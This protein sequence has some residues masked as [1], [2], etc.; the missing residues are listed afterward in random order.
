M[1]PIVARA[2]A[3]RPAGPRSP[4]AGE[5][6]GPARAVRGRRA[7]RRLASGRHLRPRARHRALSRAA[8]RFQRLPQGQ[9]RVPGRPA[10][11]RC[12][13]CASTRISAGGRTPW[14]PI[15]PYGCSSARP[16]A[17]IGRS[18]FPYRRKRKAAA[19]TAR[20]DGSPAD[21]DGLLPECA[22]PDCPLLPSGGRLGPVSAGRNGPPCTLEL[23]W[24]LPKRRLTSCSQE[25]CSTPAPP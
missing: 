10:A 5:G 19:W 21:A 15:G 25:P 16:A 9:A 4:A 2:H 12:R 11:G 24:E 3:D 23:N 22:A 17:S 13:S 1:R 6:P 20:A 18:T 14:R 8:L 7:R